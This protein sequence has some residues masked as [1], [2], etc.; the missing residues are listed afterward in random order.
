MT[1]KELPFYYHALS[2]VLFIY[3]MLKIV[4]WIIQEGMDVKLIISGRI[5]GVS[6]NRF[7]RIEA[8]RQ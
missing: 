1:T 6:L 4:K 2:E 7:V 8:F 3:E 5:G